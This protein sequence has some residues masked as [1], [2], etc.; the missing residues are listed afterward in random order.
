VNTHVNP[1]VL[2]SSGLRAGR[3]DIGG[4]WLNKSGYYLLGGLVSFDDLVGKTALVTG[5]S[6]G[7]GVHFARTLAAHGVS[8]TLTARRL[9]ALEVAAADITA[10][11][12]VVRTL[13][14]DVTDQG[15]VSA[16]LA[17]SDKPFDILVNNAG[18]SVA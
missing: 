3:G 15:S 7:L 12:G 13:A 1:N 8:V 2:W 9:D 18:I 16:A 5:A 10:A 17:A 6:G 11:G 4:A 14:M